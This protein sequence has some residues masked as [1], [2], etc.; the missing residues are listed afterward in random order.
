MDFFWINNPKENPLMKKQAQ[1]T[2]ISEYLDILDTVLDKALSCHP[3]T[4]AI[5]VDLRLGDIDPLFGYTDLMKRFI[6]SLNSQIKAQ[7]QHRAR[8]GKRV[9]PNVLR[10]IWVKEQ[11]TAEQPHYHLIL[12]FN[13][14]VYHRLGDFDSPNSLAFKIKKAWA[15]ALGYDVDEVSQ[16]PQ[17]PQGGTYRLDANAVGFDDDYERLYQRAKYLCKVYSKRRVEGQRNIGSSQR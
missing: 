13:H 11:A 2:Y 14:D 3:R 6:A 12:L 5:R 16:L 8:K 17:F 7:Q 4:F 15:C 1:Y 9:R 10:Y